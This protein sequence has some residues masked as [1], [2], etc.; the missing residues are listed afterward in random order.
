MTTRATLS[1]EGQSYTY[2]SLPA[3]EQHGLGRIDRLPFSIR[4]LLENMLRLAESP[5][6]ATLLGSE[7]E[8]TLRAGE[9]AAPARAAR[10]PLMP[11]RVILQDFTGVPC[12]VDS[13]Q[14]ATRCRSAAKTPSASTLSCPPTW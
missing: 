1:V 9:L 3:A 12:V 10:D 13:W 4:V 11:A 8:A 14:C 5:E 7:A 2:Y 6:G